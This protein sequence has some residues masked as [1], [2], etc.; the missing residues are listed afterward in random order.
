VPD[1]T[2]LT[3]LSSKPGRPVA[4]VGRAMVSQEKTVAL[5]AGLTT[6]AGIASFIIFLAIARPA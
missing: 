2:T 3:Y 4:S 5:K 1:E 6:V